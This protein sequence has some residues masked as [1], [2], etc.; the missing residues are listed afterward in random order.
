MRSARY[1]EAIQLF[2]RAVRMRPFDARARG[3]RGFAY[4][5][6]GKLRETSVDFDYARALAKDRVLLSQVYL[7]LP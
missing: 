5:K 3:E 6:M 4:L 1:D 2:D 7:N